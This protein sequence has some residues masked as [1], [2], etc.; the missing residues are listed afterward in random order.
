MF[1][2][3][4]LIISSCFLFLFFSW[5]WFGMLLV[6]WLPRRSV[7]QLSNMHSR[8][9]CQIMWRSR[10][11]Y[12]YGWRYHSSYA[13]NQTFQ[14]TCWVG[15]NAFQFLVRGNKKNG[16]KKM[17]WNSL[18]ELR[19]NYHR[20]LKPKWVGLLDLKVMKVQNVCVLV[21]ACAWMSV[22]VRDNY[23]FIMWIIFFKRFLFD[24]PL[25][26][27]TSSNSNPDIF[28]ENIWL[29]RSIIIF[30]ILSN[31]CDFSRFKRINYLKHPTSILSVLLL[32]WTQ[33][34]NLPHSNLKPVF[35]R[36]GRKIVHYLPK[37]E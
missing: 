12:R 15:S 14:E 20:L 11:C 21:H 35:P 7:Y 6:R 36:I 32:A 19:N 30:R 9:R 28:N 17:K 33:I 1:F 5:W 4:I 26:G 29:D 25:F 16:K 34:L 18:S 10:A 27:W 23:M 13:V 3:S 22:C 2:F 24:F 37:N 31:K 8:S